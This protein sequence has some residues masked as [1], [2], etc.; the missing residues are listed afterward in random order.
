MQTLYVGT[1][2]ESSTYTLYTSSAALEAYKIKPA[3]KIQWKT[4]MNLT[5]ESNDLRS[6]MPIM[7]VAAAPFLAGNSGVA[8]EI[9]IK[10]DD[11]RISKIRKTAGQ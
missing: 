3:G 4:L 5:S 6:T 10:R 9:E 1:A 7:A 8:R 11:P 2:V